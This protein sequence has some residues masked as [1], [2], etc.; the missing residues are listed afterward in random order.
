LAA[1]TGGINREQDGPGN[2]TADQADDNRH[3]QI[4]QQEIAVEGVVLEN[5]LI[6]YLPVIVRGDMP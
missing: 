1:P 4:A 2:Q 6:R 5:I 3:F